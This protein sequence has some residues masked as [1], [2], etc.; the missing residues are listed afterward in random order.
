MGYRMATTRTTD[1]AATAT[2][3]T[4]ATCTSRVGSPLDF[5]E[6][7]ERRTQITNRDTGERKENGKDDHDKDNDRDH[8]DEDDNDDNEDKDESGEH[9][10]IEGN[11]GN[12]GEEEDYGD[13]GSFRNPSAYSWIGDRHLWWK[14]RHIAPV[15][16][17][18]GLKYGVTNLGLFLVPTPTHLLLQSTDL[19]W[20]AL[21]SWFINNERVNF[22]GALCLVGCTIGS[23]LLSINLG[24]SLAAP[25][26]AI[27]VNLLSPVLLGLC[28]STLRHACTVL[29]NPRNRV[30][31]SVSALEITAI[32]LVLSSAVAFVLA[33]IMEGS[34]MQKHAS[35]SPSPPS[36]P[37]SSSSAHLA[38]T[39]ASLSWWD[40]FWSLPP[41][42]RWGV[43][44]GAMPILIYQVNCTFLTFLTSAVA[45]GVV[46]EVKVIPQW[47]LATLWGWMSGDAGASGAL[48][49]KSVLNL[50]GAVLTLSSAGVFAWQRWRHRL[51]RGTR[52]VD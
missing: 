38:M 5:L 48:A 6:E 27:V 41:A 50:V 52:S 10:H 3:M 49:R 17:L 20:T 24:Q 40:A 16:L 1:T 23:V 35:P 31:G 26:P 12:E 18:F 11:E 13:E 2:A 32:K 21:A 44:G 19:V 8:P 36:P 30:G 42:S 43:V 33:C 47:L 39:S 28:L 22:L 51:Q 46:G 14:I 7:A 34:G 9:E 29:M 45:V 15:G 4:S 37:S 25:I